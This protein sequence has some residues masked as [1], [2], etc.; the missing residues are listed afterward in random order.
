MESLS[1]ERAI[2]VD[3]NLTQTHKSN[4][5]ESDNGPCALEFKE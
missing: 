1:V 4:V 2:S 3:T 5:G